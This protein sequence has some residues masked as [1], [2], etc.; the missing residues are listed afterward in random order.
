MLSGAGRFAIPADWK[1]TR[2]TV[3]PERFICIS[4]NPCPSLHRHGFREAPP[5]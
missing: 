5:S 1:L 2:E 4:T 3:R